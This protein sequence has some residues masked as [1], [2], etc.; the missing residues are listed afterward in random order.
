MTAH[1]HTRRH[2]RVHLHTRT[3]AAFVGAPLLHDPQGAL[4][5]PIFAK[6]CGEGC[7]QDPFP[8]SQVF[9]GLV[10]IGNMAQATRA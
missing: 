10:R 5:A 9:P 1:T 8:Y 3:H 7:I 6:T 2:T 4:S